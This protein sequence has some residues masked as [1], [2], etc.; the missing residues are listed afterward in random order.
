MDR[1]LQ[2]IREAFGRVV[3]THKTHEKECELLEG[4][5]AC[6]KWA[7]VILNTLTFG[8]I[9]SIIITNQLWLKCITGAIST[10]TLAFIIYQLSFNPD[11]L[12]ARHRQIAKELWFIREK[13]INV[14]TDVMSKVLSNEQIRHRRDELMGEVGNIYKFAPQTSTKAY[15][16]AQE[17][18][19]VKDDMT[20]STAEINKFLPKE[21]WLK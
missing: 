2:T 1:N 21:L 7:N 5:V 4:K 3:Y 16:L 14:I 15:K 13:Y 17:A 11:E 8:G 20:F 9:V 18:L 19:K 6:I 12:A 10:L